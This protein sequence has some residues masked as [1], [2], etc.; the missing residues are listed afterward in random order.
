MR[1]LIRNVVEL[2]EPGVLNWHQSRKR[3]IF[4]SFGNNAE[5]RFRGL[6]ITHSTNTHMQT[7]ND[8][9]NLRFSIKWIYSES[10]IVANLFFD[11]YTF[12]CDMLMNVPLSV[13]VYHLPLHAIPKLSTAIWHCEAF[14]RLPPQLLSAIK[15]IGYR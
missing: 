10:P 2:T 5:K 8:N 13:C 11:Q 14:L 1:I 9:N 7:S 6:I 3:D 12:C 4:G 15:S